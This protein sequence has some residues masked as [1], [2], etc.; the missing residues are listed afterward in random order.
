M[1]FF[2]CAIVSSLLVLTDHYDMAL[3]HS[4]LVNKDKFGIMMVMTVAV[5]QVVNQLRGA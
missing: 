1:H 3:H 2:D 5:T 4:I